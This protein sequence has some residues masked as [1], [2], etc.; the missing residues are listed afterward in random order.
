MKK[1]ICAIAVSA[2]F[3]AAAGAQVNFDQGV[4][5]H[6]FVSQLGQTYQSIP[7]PT[8][9]TSRYTRDC[10]RFPFGPGAT[11]ILSD[12]V[13]LRSL[14]YIT[15]C[16]TEYVYQCHT[17]YVQE[18]HTVMQPGPNGTT[19]PVQQCTSK[20]VQTCYNRPVQ[21]CYERPG[22]S[23]SQSAQ[24]KMEARKLLAWERESFDVCLEGPRMDIGVNEAAYKYSVNTQGNYDTLFVMVPGRKIPM[25]ADEDGLSFTA[26]TYDSATKTYKFEVSDR[27]AAEYAGDKVVIDID[28]YK[29]NP[30]WFSGYRGSKEFTFAA[31]VGYTMS[32]T[33]KD[34]STDKEAMDNS[35]DEEDSRG[36]KKY[37]LRWGFKRVGSVSKD[38]H[39][40]KGKTP[41]VEVK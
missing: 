20:P 14:E 24:I 39:V 25:K 17:T 9:G 13:W 7:M 35:A 29:D 3:A 21:T 36:A 18:C 5:T 2:F 28:L 30:G 6:Q 15:E 37:H 32:F 10:A 11:E 16:R 22:M 12:K 27:W 4:N 19:V 23:W 40:K 26:L 41:T 38:N 34:L 31:A 1:I 8:Y 33:A